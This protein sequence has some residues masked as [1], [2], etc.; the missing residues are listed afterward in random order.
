LGVGQW[1]AFTLVNL[2]WGGGQVIGSSGGGGLADV[3]S[4]AVPFLCAAGLLALTGAFLFV[5]GRS[6]PVAAGVPVQQ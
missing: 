2:A 6:S 5:A 3:T 4:D 1:F